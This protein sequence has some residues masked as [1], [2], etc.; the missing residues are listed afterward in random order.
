M[1]ILSRMRRQL[2]GGTGDPNGV[3]PKF[4]DSAFT[5]FQPTEDWVSRWAQSDLAKSQ[6]RAFS[7]NEDSLLGWASRAFIYHV[8]RSMKPAVV[9]EIGTYM[10]GTARII[11]EALAE[12]NRGHLYTT[13]PYGAERCPKLIG[14]WPPH[15][16]RRVTF[17]ATNSMAFADELR[18][19]RIV[20]D[21][22]FI[23]GC[24]DFEYVMFDAFAMSRLLT[25]SGLLVCD[26]SEQPGVISACLEF[27]R[28]NPDFRELGSA[29]TAFDRMDPFSTANRSDVRDT[30]FLLFVGPGSE[31]VASSAFFSTGQIEIDDT[32]IRGVRLKGVRAGGGGRLFAEVWLRG[33]G[34]EMPI[35]LKGTNGISVQLSVDQFDE[36][37]PL[38]PVLDLKIADAEKKVKK[39]TVEICLF[40]V[41]D[42]DNSSLNFT[43]VSGS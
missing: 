24:H 5:A 12:N 22:A 39:Q 4:P 37:I 36:E 41:A 18:Q 32:A 8:I 43:S 34:N 21:L 31:S 19:R 42:D 38:A 2:T 16:Q 10:A 35:E 23:D 11:A 3:Q 33:F 40:W 29:V 7:G 20:V 15:L 6:E 25:K 30:S 17:S 9:V 13:D 28:L 14:A 1:G 27:L 26:N